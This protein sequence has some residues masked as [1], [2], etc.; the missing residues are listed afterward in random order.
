MKEVGGGCLFDRG[1]FFT[2]LL[3]AWPPIWGKTLISLWALVHRS[4]VNEMWQWSGFEVKRVT[5]LLAN[6]FQHTKN[7]YTDAL[8]LNFP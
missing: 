7:L 2:L 6:D 8:T 4:T 1:A 5:L 3:T